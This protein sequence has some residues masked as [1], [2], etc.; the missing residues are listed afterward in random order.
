MST[1]KTTDLNAKVI[2]YDDLKDLIRIFIDEYKEDVT[3]VVN[4][5]ANQKTLAILLNKYN[6]DIN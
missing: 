3:I 1:I 5:L 2:K 4:R 6:Y